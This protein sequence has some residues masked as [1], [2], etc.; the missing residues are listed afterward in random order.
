MPRELRPSSGGLTAVLLCAACGSAGAP[1]PDAPELFVGLVPHG[2]EPSFCPQGTNRDSVF[3]KMDDE[4]DSRCS[5]ESGDF[6]EGRWVLPQATKFPI[7][8]PNCRGTRD[9]T[10]LQFC[11]TLVPEDAFRPLT[12]DPLDV[13]QF[14]AVLKF[15]ERCPPHAVEVSKLVVNEDVDTDNSPTGA[16]SSE[17]LYPNE[18]VDGALG[19][20]TRL[21][22]CYFRSAP[23][24]VEVMTEFPDVGFAYAVFHDFEGPQPGWV[25]RKRWQWSDDSNEERPVNSYVPDPE[26]DEMA[27]EFSNLVENPLRD[28]ARDTCFDFARVR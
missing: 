26:I 20:Y 15:G 28:R 11:R 27:A 8:S 3:F 1:G 14:Y 2:S 23:S 12:S 25:I 22:F 13:A 16:D 5:Y 6:G 19:N 7:P 18:I 4:D 17:L 9:H 24:S 21:F 10:L